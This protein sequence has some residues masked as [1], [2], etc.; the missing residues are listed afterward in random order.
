MG[1]Y[2]WGK[3]CANIATTTGCSTGVGGMYNSVIG[4]LNVHNS[5]IAFPSSFNNITGV[6]QKNG[7]PSLP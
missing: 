3:P 4:A 7:S 1:D 5:G 6:I 2:N